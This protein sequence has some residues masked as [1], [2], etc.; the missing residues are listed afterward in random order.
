MA[1]IAEAV[2]ELEQERSRMAGRVRKLDEAISALRKLNG[3][4]IRAKR[5][6]SS[7]ARRKIGAAQRARWTKLKQ[8]ILFHKDK[9]FLNVREPLQEL[10]ESFCQVVETLCE[11]FFHLLQALINSSKGF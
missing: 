9:L 8:K 6:M 7:A 2:K 3:N 5:T 10:V 4:F 1:N 11:A